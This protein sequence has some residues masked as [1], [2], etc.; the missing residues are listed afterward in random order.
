L[1][2]RGEG[3]RRA[4]GRPD[5]GGAL[6]AGK[7]SAD[8][9]G[10]DAPPWSGG[11][12]ALADAGHLAVL[13]AIW[14]AE[15]V[16]AREQRYTALFLQALPEGARHPLSHQAKWLWRT[17]RAAELAGLDAGQVLAGAIGGRDLTGA[18]DIAAV[19]G[20]RLRRRTQSLVPRSIIID[21]I[22]M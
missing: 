3:S 16:P 2:G 9:Q 15:T 4:V 1:D 13:H 20:A 14:T 7:A 11:R 22:E 19:I 6:R 10:A 12:R 17:L 18:R 5:R 8:P 21:T